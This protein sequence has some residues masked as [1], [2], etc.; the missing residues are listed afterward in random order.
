MM[1]NS[2]NN[3]RE[4]ETSTESRFALLF[5]VSFILSE[6][7]I[8]PTCIPSARFTLCRWRQ[9][10]DSDGIILDSP[11]PID[12]DKRVAFSEGEWLEGAGQSLAWS[13]GHVPI[14]PEGDLMGHLDTPV[15]R[16]CC[17]RLNEPA[18]ERAVPA[19]N[20]GNA[21]LGR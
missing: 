15:D 19:G 3:E 16:A 12:H 7:T 6:M 10:Q 8:P 1:V 2:N 13:P 9:V 17:P 4:S 11:A 21:P 20:G 14:G 5:S 18:S